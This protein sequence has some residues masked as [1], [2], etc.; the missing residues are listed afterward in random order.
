MN[1]FDPIQGSNKKSL[2]NLALTEKSKYPVDA[3]GITSFLSP[4][5]HIVSCTPVVGT[6]TSTMSTAP[7]SEVFIEILRRDYLALGRTRILFLY[8]GM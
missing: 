3:R 6:C 8:L 2:V 1:G 7:I 4:R 5:D